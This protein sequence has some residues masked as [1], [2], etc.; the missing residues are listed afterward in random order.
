[1]RVKSWCKRGRSCLFSHTKEEQMYHP[2]VYKTLLCKNYPDCDKI[3]CPFAHGIK[4]LRYPELQ[5]PFTRVAGPENFEEDMINSLSTHDLNKLINENSQKTGELS[6]METI[7]NEFSNLL[8]KSDPLSFSIFMDEHFQI[9][10]ATF[11]PAS[12]KVLRS[13]FIALDIV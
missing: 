7:K 6:L 12:V 13:G 2:E 1:M 8:S 5:H 3:F 4:D 10:S 9:F 11:D